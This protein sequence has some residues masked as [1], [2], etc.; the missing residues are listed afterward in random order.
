MLGPGE[1]PV[2]FTVPLLDIDPAAVPEEPD[3]PDAPPLPPPLCALAIDRNPQT[4]A[5]ARTIF[6]SF[7]SSSGLAWPPT[8]YFR[9]SSCCVRCN[10]GSMQFGSPGGRAA[11]HGNCRIGVSAEETKRLYVSLASPP[12]LHRND[13]NVTK[14]DPSSLRSGL[15]CICASGVGPTSAAL[16]GSADNPDTTPELLE[17]QRQT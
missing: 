5:A 17:L 16:G 6:V 9:R 7:K 10:L 15:A 13:V 12:S 11:N 4:E 8:R 1:P 3:A 2:P 14:S